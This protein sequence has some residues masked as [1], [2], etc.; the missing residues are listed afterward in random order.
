MNNKVYELIDISNGEVYQSLGIFST[1]NNAKNW[2]LDA[3]DKHTSFSEIGDYDELSET[4]EIKIRVL[5]C[6][7]IGE[8]RMDF[9]DYYDSLDLDDA[10]G[11]DYVWMNDNFDFAQHF[12]EAGQKEALE[13]YEELC[14]DI[15]MR[16]H[17]SAID[18]WNS[19]LA[20]AWKVGQE[21]YH[22]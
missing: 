7:D 13:K 16:Y 8:M 1:K 12:W 9:E 3:L 21:L 4:F 2:I 11:E 5:N 6:Y 20:E 14:I 10:N 17:T 22:D 19:P 15:Y 18:D